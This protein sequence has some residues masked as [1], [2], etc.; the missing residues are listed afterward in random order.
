MDRPIIFTGAIPRST[1]ILN[2]WQQSMIGLGKL[3]KATLGSGTLVEGLA[4]APTSPGSLEVTIAPGQ[5]Y[6]LDPVDA[7]AYGSLPVDTTEIMKQGLSLAALLLSCPAPTTSGDSIDY[8]IEA[9]YE[10][11]DSDP[12]VLPYYN[13]ANPSQAFSGPNNSGAAQNTIRQG[14]CNVQVK[15]GAAAATGSQTIPAVDSG[16]VGLWVVTV[17]YGDT[18]IAASQIAEYVGAPFI[19]TTLTNA[20]GLDLPNVFT[21]QQTLEGGFSSGGPSTVPS[22]TLAAGA[23]NAGQ[24]QSASI[25]TAPDTGVANACAIALTPT[26]I[27]LTPGM[28]V[29]IKS[30]A[31]TNTGAATL[32]VNGLSTL[33]ILLAKNTPLIGGELVAGYGAICR[34]NN[35]ATAWELTWSGAG[36]F[37]IAATTANGAV[38]LS[39]V[40]SALPVNLHNNFIPASGTT[41][42][43]SL[44]FTAPSNGFIFAIATQNNSADPQPTGIVQT[45][46]INGTSHGTDSTLVSKTNYGAAAVA[47]GTACTVTSTLAAGTSTGTFLS[48]DQIISYLFIPNP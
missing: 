39:Q 3:I 36:A 41:Y 15:A 40:E 25:I 2:G 47:A 6:A 13:A 22:A 20:A 34:L 35:A 17:A 42:T 43:S 26:P 30:V 11:V 44:S 24:A 10:D 31:Y 33:P 4:C 37:G 21:Q 12:V 8:L 32:A 19:P 5:I 27:A 1:D 28:A 23:L 18:A 29:S 7:S 38:N 46:S 14:V 16:F 9:A 45:V 48:V